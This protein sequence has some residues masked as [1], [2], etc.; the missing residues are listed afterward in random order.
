VLIIFCSIFLLSREH[1]IALIIADTPG[2]CAQIF[3]DFGDK[4]VVHD[5]N[6]EEPISAMMAS[7]TQEAD[8]GVVATLDEVRH[9]FEDGDTVK[10]TEVEGM[11][12]LNE[13]THKITVIGIFFCSSL[14]TLTH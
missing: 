9:G 7:V 14:Q 6:G 11:T 12:E 4:F 8:G 13:T 1:N 5:V 2:L 3:T 10:F